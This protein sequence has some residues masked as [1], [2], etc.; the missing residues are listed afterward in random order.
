MTSRTGD[1][2]ID[3]LTDLHTHSDLTDGADPPEQ[4]AN[5]ASAAGLRVWGLSEHVRADA[6]WVP[7]YVA[8]V[9][10]LRRDDVEVRCGLEAKIL[11]RN[12]RLDLPKDLSGVDYVLVA[13]H[14]YPG[15][16]TPMT[17][18]EV[19]RRLDRGELTPTDVADELVRAVSIA[20]L[21]APLPA[22]VAHPFSLL[23]RIG[24]D[25]SE[26][27]DEHLR[28]L[29][30]ACLVAGASVEVNEKWRCP[31]PEI[32]ARLFDLGVELVPGSNAHCAADIAQWPYLDSAVASLSA[33]AA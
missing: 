11:S 30:G 18:S 27:T 29:A 31:S 10:S 22:I 23:S 13:D 19:G 26:V 21:R 5:A 24:V 33:Y 12:G 3:R 32:F 17:A 20:V 7:D 6:A 16:S 1:P 14:R 28:T 4:M 8:R 25:I 2:V 15:E 9:R